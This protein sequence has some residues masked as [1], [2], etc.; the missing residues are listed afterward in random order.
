MAELDTERDNFSP[1]THHN[2]GLIATPTEF[3]F[4]VDEQMQDHDLLLHHVV[5]HD[6]ELYAFE[7]SLSEIL[8]V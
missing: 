1:T 6:H 7:S 2:N 3:D 4:E 5:Q 8:G